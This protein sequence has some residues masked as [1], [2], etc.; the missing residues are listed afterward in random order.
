MLATM[1]TNVLCWVREPRPRWGQRGSGGKREVPNTTRRPKLA[2]NLS[3]A[4]KKRVRR[5]P[6]GPAPAAALQVAWQRRLREQANNLARAL[7]MLEQGL[8]MMS[9]PRPTALAR[10]ECLRG[11]GLLTLLAASEVLV[12][13]GWFEAD[14][15]LSGALLEHKPPG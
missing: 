9:E 4:A 12:V 13:A 3:P 7:E 2:A 15:A 1:I 8:A 6:P 5:P 11:A 10:A 14:Q